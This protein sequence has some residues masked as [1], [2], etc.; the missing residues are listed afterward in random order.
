MY[1]V[2][3]RSQ[4]VTAL[5]DRFSSFLSNSV[6][7]DIILIML[8]TPVKLVNTIN[9]SNFVLGFVVVESLLAHH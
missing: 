3:C 2:V 6:F 5:K 9:H 8:I 4:L 1:K 7:S